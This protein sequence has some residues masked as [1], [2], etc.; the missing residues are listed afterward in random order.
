ME[1]RL[2]SIRRVTTTEPEMFYAKVSARNDTPDGFADAE[3]EIEM[4]NIDLMNMTLQQ[5]ETLAITRV[6]S[7]LSK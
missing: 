1:F 5:I 3:F 6:Q 7:V 4:K 2:G